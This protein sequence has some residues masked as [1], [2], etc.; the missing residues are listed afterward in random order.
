M[1]KIKKRE[2]NYVQVSNS[3]LRN[4]NMSFKAKGLFCYMFSMSDNWN[5][6]IKSIASQQKDGVASVKSSLQE[7]KELGYISYTKHSDGTGTYFLDDEPKVE[8]PNVGFIIKRKST[9]IKKNQLPKNN[10][11]KVNPTKAE[12]IAYIEEKQLQVDGNHFYE[13]FDVSG[14]VDSKGNKVKNWKQKL[15]TWNNYAEKG[16]P[17]GINTPITA[18]SGFTQ[19]M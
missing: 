4:S 17:K 2:S 1:N 16:K 9:P 12:I 18:P 14:W 15:L 19:A 11:T 6:T 5:F 13:Y 8:N 7:L 3:F 10:N